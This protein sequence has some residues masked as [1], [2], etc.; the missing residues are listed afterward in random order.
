MVRKILVA[1]SF[2]P[3]VFRCVATASSPSCPAPALA[4][5]PFCALRF[6]YRYTQPDKW[7]E[8]RAALE[9]NRAAFDEVWFST[10]VNF[11]PLAWHEEHARQCAAAADDLR[12]L[13]IV[14]SIEIQTIIG[15][16]D[17][18]L[19]AGD[20]SGQDWGTWVGADGSAAKRVSCPHDPRLAAYFARVGALHA[21]WRPGSMWI[22]DDV[23]LRNRAPI[24]YGTPELFGC[25]CDRCLADFAKT[26]GRSWTRADLTAAI[27]RDKSVEGRWET[28]QCANFA[29]LCR[30]IAAAV[31]KVS[32][33]T[34]FGYQYGFSGRP[35]IVKGIFD[36][37]GIPVRLRPGA[38]AYWDTDPHAQL[39]KAYGLQVLSELMGRPDWIGARCPEIE[40]CPRTFACRTAQGVVLEAFENLALGMDFLSL[41]VADARGDESTSYYADRLFPR[42]AAAHPF[43]K[44]YRDANVGTRPCGFTVAGGKPPKLVASR[45]VPVVG[46]GGRSLGL[47]PDVLAIPART[48]G[49][50]WAAKSYDPQAFVMQVASSV[51]LTNFY[52][53]CDRAS[54]GRLPVLFEEAVMAFAVPRVR[55]DG[56]LVT[57]ALVNASIDR[58]D[59]VVVRLRGVPANAKGAVWHQ[60]EAD[61]VELALERRAGETRVRLPRIGAWECGYLDFK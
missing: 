19:A 53:Q 47:L 24:K 59:S 55:E 9:K 3:L 20:C 40:S 5:V 36:G 8:M 13:G 21:A 2:S 44:N 25:F 42:L 32:P 51:A 26:E 39:E 31:H 52:A 38:G 7:P 12:K 49:S 54:G 27:C 33:E 18:I 16:S 61:P 46:A 17:G 43:L 15:H 60:P 34:V 57:L 6:G 28:Y 35:A 37:C 48:A 41:F 14:P 58:Q 10:G 56:T 22:D 29:E 1:L 30:T 45:G 4:D 50:A 11:P 23:T